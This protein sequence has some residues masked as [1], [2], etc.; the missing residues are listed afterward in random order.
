MSHKDLPITPPSPSGIK[1][2]REGIGS[3]RYCAS[4]VGVDTRT[5][6]R[7]EYIGEDPRMKRTPTAQTWGLFLLATDQHPKYKIEL[8]G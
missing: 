1:A 7:Y 6:E 4:L 5:W 8:K 2:Q 3:Q